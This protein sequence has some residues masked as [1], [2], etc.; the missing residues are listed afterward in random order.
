MRYGWRFGR[1]G[2]M[3]T[4]GIEPSFPRCD[5]GVLP[6]HHVPEIILFY[7]LLFYR[8]GSEIQ[9]IFKS[10]CTKK[11]ELPFVIAHNLFY[12]L[13]AGLFRAVSRI[14]NRHQL[15]YCYIVRNAQYCSDFFRIER[16][17]PARGQP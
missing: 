5:R 13:S 16:A 1:C 6:L 3:E 7:F 12:R 2:K 11:L 9:I 14:T 17:N 4:K 15:D 10:L 8:I